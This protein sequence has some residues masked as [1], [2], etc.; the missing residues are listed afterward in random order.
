MNKVVVTG[1]GAVS[2]IG[3]TVDEYWNGLIQGKNGVHTIQGIS[4]E[5]HDTKVAAE[6]NDEFEDY[7]KKFWKKRN[8][9]VTTRAVRMGLSAAVEAIENS[10]INFEE[11][12]RTRAAVIYGVIDNSFK[13]YE[14]DNM[15][16]MVLK[17]M[18]SECPALI[19]MR[20]QLHGASLSLATA[21]ATSANSIVLGKQMIETG[22]YDVVIVGGL[23]GNLTHIA[24]SGFNQLFAL[25]VNPD[26]ETACRP[27]T[28]NRDGFVIGEGAGALILESEDFAKR[29]GAH[30][31]CELAGCAMYSE[32]FN[33][34][35]PQTDGI[36][37]AASMTM[38]LKNAGI[39]P[40]EVDYINAHG[41][42]TGLNDRYETMAIKSVFG[43]RA[44]EIPVSSVKSSIGHTLGACGALEA[45]ASIKAIENGIIPPTLHYDEPDPELDLDYVPNKAREHKTD[46]VLSNS[47]AFGGRD[48]TLIFRRYNG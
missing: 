14:R 13:D 41:T 12:D 21:C 19:S 3:N 17:E 15:S 22:V 37:M 10:G 39:S 30:I 40:D 9:S 1:M 31:H 34:T 43:D 8:L 36:G 33:M 5:E 4:A 26:P 11:H 27:F 16:N 42:S 23:S 2:S 7:V 28:K 47:F 46:V 18:P 48:T 35:A 44:K 38:A 24:L 32:A 20:Y 29:R 6:V 25:S 45:I